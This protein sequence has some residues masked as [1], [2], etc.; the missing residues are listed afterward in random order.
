V[1]YRSLLLVAGMLA[2]TVASAPGEAATLPAGFAESQVATG[3]SSP[4]A[5]AIAPDGRIFVCQQ[6]GR[7][8][9]IKNGALL[10]TP[11]LIVTVDAQGERGL[12]GV[13]FDPNFAVNQFVYVY[14]T[15][16]TPTIHNRVSRFVADGDV[17]VAGSE[18]VIL[19]LETLSGATNHNGGAIH[20]AADGKLHIAVGDNANSANA[21]TL[22]NRLGKM[23]RINPDGS[24]PTDNPF[25]TTA[26]GNNRAIWALGLRNPFNF[27][28]QPGTGRIFIND[29]GQ[30]TWEEINDGI[31]GSN[32]GWPNTEGETSNPA[33]RS[34]LFAY[35]HGSGATTGCAITGAAFYNPPVVQFPAAYV[36]D[37]FFAD[38]CSGWIRRYDPATDSVTAFATGISNPVDLKVGADGSLYYLSISA[39]ALF[40]VRYTASEAPTIAIHPASQTAPLTGSATFAVV[41]SGTAPLG[42]Q[43]QRNGVPIPGATA[44]SYTLDPVAPADDGASF[45]CVVSNA[46]GTATSNAATLTVTPNAPPS[47]TITLPAT[48]TLYRAGDTISYAGTGA[49]P[50]DGALPGSA[51]TWTVVFHHDTH[52]HP[53]LPAT[54]GATSGSFV[55]A[56]TGHPE[57]NVWYRIHLTVTDS[58]GLTHSSV[59]DV[60]PRTVTLQLTT[61]PAGLQVTLEGQ[62]QATPLSGPSVVGM[63]RTLG[64]VSPQTAGGVTYEFVSWSDGGAASHTI[65]TPDTATTYTATFRPILVVPAAPS[66]LQVR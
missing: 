62:P 11:F 36:G 20:F 4:T 24:I 57:A 3:L 33:F 25:Y 54:S 35:G 10:P 48:G 37:Y 21:Q 42:Y 5:M 17:A 64:V 26:T 63:M 30:N 45:R 51:F 49:D 60:Q 19:E 65:A 12:L 32:Y 14:Y 41:A 18:T 52:T 43:W 15:A 59:R 29:V 40:R 7:L 46:F 34:P 2:W 27:A 28:V 23:L 16:T 31:A 66:Q 13:A 55:T 1:R 53:F 38:Y 9:V 39:G 6:N 22:A 44:A 50:E 47:G 61:S 8:R 58:G 56:T